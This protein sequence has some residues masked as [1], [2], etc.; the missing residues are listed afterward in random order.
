MSKKLAKRYKITRRVAIFLAAAP[1]FQL[2][3]CHTVNNQIAAGVLN[4]LPSLVFQVLLN[5]G[6]LPIQLLLNG[7]QTGGDDLN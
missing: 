4:S 2:G 1:L 3:Q 6:L 7:G 5:F